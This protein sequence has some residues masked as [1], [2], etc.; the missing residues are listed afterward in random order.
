MVYEKVNLN[1]LLLIDIY[2]KSSCIFKETQQ[3]KNYTC[4]CHKN[5]IIFKSLA[6]HVFYIGCVPAM[7][8]PQPHT[9]TSI[10]MLSP[11]MTQEIA[12]THKMGPGLVHPRQDQ[13]LTCTP[14]LGSFWYPLV[15]V[16]QGQATPSFVVPL[17]QGYAL[18][19]SPP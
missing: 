13:L 19:I 15:S 4:S 7:Q 3:Q 8:I 9:Q 16:T 2:V 1:F 6:T 12:T 5:A 14:H 18:G 17:G 10:L 11:I